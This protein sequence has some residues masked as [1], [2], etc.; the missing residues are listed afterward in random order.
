MSMTI[1]PRVT[2]PTAMPPGTGFA[3]ATTGNP[4]AFFSGK[5]VRVTAGAASAAGG[6]DPAV[7]GDLR[8][9]DALGM[10]FKK[11]FDLPVPAMPEWLKG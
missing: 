9:D 6:V 10:L 5:S 2:Q 3:D 1:G 8:R 4:P 11:A 7:E